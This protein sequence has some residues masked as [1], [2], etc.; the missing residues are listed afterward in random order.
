MFGFFSSDLRRDCGF[1]EK[2]RGFRVVRRA[3]S[4]TVAE[5][6]HALRICDARQAIHA[7]FRR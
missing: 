6:F 3:S 2:L 5:E 7:R 4:V 1:K